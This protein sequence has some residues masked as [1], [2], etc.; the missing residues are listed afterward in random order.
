M[1]NPLPPALD[2]QDI[3]ELGLMAAASPD[4]AAALLRSLFAAGE[5]ADAPQGKPY[6]P[7]AGA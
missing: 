7:R 2:S 6:E 4:L 1:E 3:L 5:P